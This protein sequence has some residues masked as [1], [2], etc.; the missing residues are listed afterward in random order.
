MDKETSDLLYQTLFLPLFTYCSL[1][2]YGTTPNYLK[3]CIG[4]IESRAARV[5]AAEL[6]TIAPADNPASNILPSNLHVIYIDRM[7]TRKDLVPEF[8]IKDYK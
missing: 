7:R 6:C 3:N 1:N 5:A 4:K 2:M 8:M